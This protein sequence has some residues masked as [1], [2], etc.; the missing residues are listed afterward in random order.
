[1]DSTTIRIWN[2]I[3]TILLF[4]LIIMNTTTGAIYINSQF[5]KYDL[6]SMRFLKRGGLAA[7][8]YSSLPLILNVLL[9]L[10]SYFRKEGI[11]CL[12]TKHFCDICGI[13]CQLL[14]VIFVSFTISI[15]LPC[16]EKSSYKHSSMGRHIGDEWG[17]VLCYSDTI[18]KVKQEYA[19]LWIM[20]I[21]SCFEIVIMF[22]SSVMFCCGY[23]RLCPCCQC[24]EVDHQ[25]TLTETRHEHQMTNL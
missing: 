12:S 9:G 6:T 23:V 2:L 15:Y 17:D 24:P 1:M 11:C 22:M 20:L 7:P 4:L 25:T 19:M 8:V 14:W 3:G 13:I 16:V 5:E 21:A 10:L 18:H